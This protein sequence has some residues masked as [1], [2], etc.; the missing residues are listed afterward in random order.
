MF[1]RQAYYMTYLQQR[2][3]LILER[4]K[5]PMKKV[6]KSWGWEIWFANSELYC[7][8]HL[9]VKKDMWS[10][11]GRYHYHEIKDE[12]FYIMKG[13]LQLDYVTD[14]NEFKTLILEKGDSFRVPPLMKHRFCALN[15]AGCDFIE[16]STKH[17]DSDSYR[18][19]WDE[20]LKE[21]IH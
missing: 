6:D 2:A 18:V 10:S 11:E 3:K 21:W 20:D 19:A 7:G 16:A 8:K 14:D 17:R 1:H 5:R 12:T 13:R 4:E 9:H 15:I